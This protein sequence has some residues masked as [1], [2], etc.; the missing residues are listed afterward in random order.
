ML[1]EARFEELCAIEDPDDRDDAIHELAHEMIVAGATRMDTDELERL[2]T[3]LEGAVAQR[4]RP[5]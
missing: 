2:I 5:N 1:L 4:K 3:E